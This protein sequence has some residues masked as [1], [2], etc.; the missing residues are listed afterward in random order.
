[1]ADLSASH[2]PG[3]DDWVADVRRWFFAGTVS[4]ARVGAAD[5]LGYEAADPALQS[6]YWPDAPAEAQ[7][8]IPPTRE[9]P[10]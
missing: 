3:N 5:E 10:L 7:L 4:A 1:M 2:G 6:R 8:R 9:R